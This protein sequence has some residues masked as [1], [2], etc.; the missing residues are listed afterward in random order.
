MGRRLWLAVVILAAGGAM[1]ADRYQIDPFHTTVG[2]SIRRLVINNVKGVFKDFS[3]TVEYDGQ[4]PA[5]LRVDGSI[6]AA[7]VDTGIADRD[8]HL[9]NA[10]FLDVEQHPEITFSTKRVEVRDGKAFLVGPF[11]MHG[12]T[13]EIEL[14]VAI[15]GP[16]TDPM[17][18]VR[19][20]LEAGLA[21]N[22]QDYGIRWS[23]VLDN[24]GL[25]VGDEVKVEINAEAV[26]QA[27][28]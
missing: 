16:I 26:R 6:R 22:R 27:A 10:D 14:P 4:D 21:L 2:F 7:S 1:G 12:V 18:K 20:G 17:G 5:T 15:S 13:R 8:Q 24:G 23:K 3:G 28:D 11:T 19:I 9:R 25:A